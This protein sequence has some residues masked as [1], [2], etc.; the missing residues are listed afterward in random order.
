MSLRSNLP[1]FLAVAFALVVPPALAQQDSSNRP[2]QSREQLEFLILGPV[3]A[4]AEDTQ[5]KP[6]QVRKSAFK[7]DLLGSEDELAALAPQSGDTVSVD[8][9]QYSW[10]QATSQDGPAIDLDTVLGRHEWSVA[11]AYREIDSHHADSALLGIGSDDAVRVWLNGKLVH[12]KWEG[13]PLRPDQDIVRVQLR[14][15][16]NRLLLKIVNWTRDWGFSARVMSRQALAEKLGRTVLQGDHDSLKLLLG[17]GV[18]PNGATR[19]GVKPIQLAKIHGDPKAVQLLLD[20]GAQD[21]PPPEPAVVATALFDNGSFDGL[22]GLSVLVARD[23]DVLFE[24]GLGFADVPGQVPVTTKTK[25]RIG[26]VTKQ[27]TAS[28]ILRLVEQ[29]KLK[30][31]DSLDKFL[32]NFPRGDEVT[33]HHLLTHTSGIPSYTDDPNFFSTV[34]EPISED[35]LVATIAAAANDY[36]FDPGSQFHYNNSG[37]FLLGH[38]VRKVSGQSLGDYLQATF[39][40]P[41]GMS[42]TGMHSVDLQLEHEAKGYSIEAGKPNDA[43]NWAM[44]RAGGAGALYSTVH[45]LMKWNEAVFSGKVLQQDTLKQAFTPVEPSGM[46]MKYGYGWM[47]GQQ[48]GLPTISHAGGLHG[49]VSYLVRF[50]EQKLT[51]AALHNASP[52]VAELQP[53]TVASRLAEL[54]L[55]KEMEPRPIYQVDPN[56]DPD[57]FTR[58]VGRYDYGGAVMVVTKEGDKLFAQL[59]GQPKL[60]IYPAGGTLFFWKAVAASVEFVL[61]DEGNCVAAR[62]SQGPSNFE[63]KKLEDIKAVAMTPEQLDEY[64]GVYDYIQAKLTVTRQGQQLLAQMQGQPAFP[65]FPEGNNTFAWKVIIAKIEFVRDDDGKV[66]GAI[67]SQGGAKIEVKKIE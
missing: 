1:H 42:D 30:L 18:D 36:S 10:Q 29:G 28:A 11:Y 57:Q 23:G 61:D 50:P 4:H 6:A 26:S 44:S 22:P 52:P 65:I 39:F 45:D 5:P 64:V 9:K 46:G 16:T 55:W 58:Y 15:G 8:G 27:F 53:G 3:P 25:F 34:T 59:S 13:R 37:Y 20:A 54:F 14:E 49:F 63:A 47:M 41:L 40:G 67:H 17:H 7:A 38:V 32:P 48:R 66:T 60:E 43:L 19:F 12:S 31:T 56:V 33:I 2:D 21:L 62:H 51:V 24:H 35:E